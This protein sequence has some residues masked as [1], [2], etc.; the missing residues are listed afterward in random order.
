MN[1]D[2]ITGQPLFLGR[3]LRFWIIFAVIVLVLAGVLGEFL[4]HAMLKISYTY[5]DQAVQ[6][7]VTY[8]IQ[9]N[10]GNNLSASKLPG[11][12]TLVS[13][14]AAKVIASDK[15]S[16]TIAMLSKLPQLSVLR[17]TL[18]LQPQRQVEHVGSGSLGCGLTNPNGTFTYPCTSLDSILKFNRP[19]NGIWDTSQDKNS[20]EIS[21]FRRFQDGFLG[22]L[23]PS[24]EST[25]APRLAYIVAGGSEQ[26]IPISAGFFSSPQDSVYIL[27]DQ[28]DSHD[29]AFA[30]MNITTGRIEY[31]RDY[32]QPQSVTRIDRQASFNAASDSALCSL[33]AHQL[34]CYYAAGKDTAGKLTTTPEGEPVPEA[35]QQAP[36]SPTSARYS[37]KVESI[38]VDQPTQRTTYSLTAPAAFN[39]IYQTSSGTLYLT[40]IDRLYQ[41]YTAGKPTLRFVADNVS[42]AGASG[43]SIFYTTD[44]GLFE[45]HENAQTADLRFHSDHLRTVNLT[46]YGQS[47]L[48]NAYVN[49]A[50][51]DSDVG[52]TAHLY[53]LSNNILTI[54]QKRLEDY[55]PYDD[56][57]L[58]KHYLD[59]D[60]SRF[61]I[62]PDP[63]FTNNPDGTRSI[64]FAATQSHVDMIKARLKSD[65]LVNANTK[66]IVPQ[67][68]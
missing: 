18:T 30:I 45:F 15:D 68:Q 33:G 6:T 48:L 7:N 44:A 64:D 29:R 16:T 19:D 21:A 23:L 43:G 41:L 13:R 8:R 51:P 22:W 38:S 34:V 57:N 61:Y 24:N 9:D 27:V 32:T 50:A 20:F 59:Y 55:L 12:I 17:V 53:Q 28:A 63:I 39:S 52:S 65:G 31:Y 10:K 25:A 3:S 2:P 56:P 40:S 5:A 49:T 14:S 54:G 37:A 42:Q 62:S 36:P 58:P 11:G 1:N 66:F 60:S 47:V 35:Q 67:P 26:N 4:T 46:T